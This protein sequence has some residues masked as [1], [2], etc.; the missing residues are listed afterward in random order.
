[1]DTPVSGRPEFI[2]SRSEP[3]GVPAGQ[4][5]DEETAQ[6]GEDHLGD[7]ELARAWPL[8]R[9]DRQ[10]RRQVLLRGTPAEPAVT[11]RVVHRQPDGLIEHPGFLAQEGGPDGADPLRQGLP[12]RSRGDRGQRVA[13]APLA[14]LEDGLREQVI[15]PVEVVEQHL[16]R[17]A[18]RARRPPEREVHQ[19]VDRQ[20]IGHPVQQFPAPGLAAR[21]TRRSPVAGAPRRAVVAGEVQSSIHA[22]TFSQTGLAGGPEFRQAGHQREAVRRPCRSRLGVGR[23]GTRPPRGG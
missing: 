10:Q 21:R 1:M 17:G 18:G 15:G 20:V 9:A 7:L 11:R 2:L 23:P 3:G 16:V 6:G 4:P 14:Q 19:A 22:T 12:V 8:R 5:V 13:H